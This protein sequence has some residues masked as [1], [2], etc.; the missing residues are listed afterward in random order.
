MSPRHALSLTFVAVAVMQLGAEG[1]LSLDDT[2]EKRLPGW[3]KQGRRVRIRNLLNHTSGIPN[4]MEFEPPGA[5]C[6]V[7]HAS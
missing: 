7:T 5:R 4:Y 1:R 3:A 6:S 2:V